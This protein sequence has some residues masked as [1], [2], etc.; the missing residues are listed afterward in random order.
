MSA[1]DDDDI[2]DTYVNRAEGA[3]QGAVL[4]ATGKT[5]ITMYLENDVLSHFREQAG[6]AGRGY[7][8]LINDS[9]RLAMLAAA[10]KQTDRITGTRR[11]GAK[12]EVR[13]RSFI[14][15]ESYVSSRASCSARSVK[16]AASGPSRAPIHLVF[17]PTNTKA[18]HP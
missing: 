2:L 14:W 5:R 15:V 4:S 16:K 6:S 13:S 3:K 1:T 7:Q 18:V 10:E 9:L 8:T 12:L 17:P 11:K